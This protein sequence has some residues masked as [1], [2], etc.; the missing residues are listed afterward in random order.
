[1]LLF[2]HEIRSTRRSCCAEGTAGEL[3]GIWKATPA[4]LHRH[5]IQRREP[6]SSQS[7]ASDFGHRKWDLQAEAGR[8]ES[9]C[10]SRGAEGAGQQD[11][12]SSRCPPPSRHA[13]THACPHAPAFAFSEF[14]G[15]GRAV[16]QLRFVAITHDHH[17]HR[18]DHP[19]PSLSIRPHPS[20]DSSIHPRSSWVSSPLVPPL[21]PPRGPLAHASTQRLCTRR[22]RSSS[23]TLLLTLPTHL[24]LFKP[25]RDFVLQ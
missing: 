8:V 15:P 17:L 2:E 19:L 1:M 5:D 10:Q 11:A 16:C 4:H 9:S 18:P 13:D 6:A 20:F 24:D 21:V 25:P 12:R 22:P 23:P 7:Q 14:R 3:L